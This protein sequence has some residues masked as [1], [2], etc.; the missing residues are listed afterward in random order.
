M[1]GDLHLA[2][3]AGLSAGRGSLRYQ[4]TDYTILDESPSEKVLCLSQGDPILELVSYPEA[5]QL[6]L[7]CRFGDFASLQ[8]DFS[9]QHQ[10]VFVQSVPYNRLG[11]LP[12]HCLTP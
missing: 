3:Q 11:S 6:A 7:S 1:T 12:G 8:F 2:D 9:G 5:L 4:G 10:V